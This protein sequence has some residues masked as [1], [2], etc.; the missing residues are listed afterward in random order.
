MRSFGVVGDKDDIRCDGLQR[1]DNAIEDTPVTH[2][3]EALRDPRQP[4][5]CSSSQDDA[6]WSARG[7]IRNP[8]RSAAE[9]SSTVKAR[10]MIGACMPSPRRS[11]RYRAQA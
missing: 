4:A 11:L 10:S 9:S 7:Q 8:R 3:L 5:A 1:A 2:D 6:D